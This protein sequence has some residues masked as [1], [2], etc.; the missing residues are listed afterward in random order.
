MAVRGLG[1]PG[2]FTLTASQE[3]DAPLAAALIE[4]FLTDVVMADAAYDADALR[5]ALPI[6][7]LAVSLNNPSRALKHYLDKQL[8]AQRHL[9]CS[10]GLNEEEIQAAFADY[11]R[12]YIC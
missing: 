9:E 6:R 7:V 12:R 10:F 8:Y 3:A 4:E 11:R 1:C 2:R 5:Q